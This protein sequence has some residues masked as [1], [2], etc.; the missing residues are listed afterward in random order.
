[1]TL[2]LTLIC[3]FTASIQSVLRREYSKYSEDGELFNFLQSLVS[4]GVFAAS[5]LMRGLDFPSSPEIYLYS[6]GFAISYITAITAAL[7]ALACGPFGTT[8]LIISYSTVLPTIYGLLFLGEPLR[9]TN[10]LG[11]ACFLISLWLT[12]SDRSDA[13]KNIKGGSKWLI[14]VCA[15][16]VGNGFCSIVQKAE[17]N[18]LGS[19][20]SDEFMICALMAV[21]LVLGVAAVFRKHQTICRKAV[22]Y[23]LLCGAANGL[24]NLLV[25]TII[26]FAAISVFFPMISAGQL[27]ASLTFA[28]FLYREKLSR[29]M[30]P[31][32]ALGLA[33][34]VL[35]NI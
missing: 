31:A 13:D 26:A 16:F 12:R 11:I 22:L 9:V 5:G 25:L 1:M 35:L 17:Q 3:I 6:L 8:S 34:L 4:L 27:L 14:L 20:Y 33:S 30:Y 23:P 15:A 10:A 19:G 32:A 29:R 28:A 7:Y 21:T 18:A 2:V 24:T